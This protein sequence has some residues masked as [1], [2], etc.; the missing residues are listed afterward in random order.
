MVLLH[1]FVCSVCLNFKVKLAKQ[2]TL[3]CEFKSTSDS[4]D[5]VYRYSSLLVC[6][7]DGNIMF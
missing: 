1:V 7:M 4:T 3:L 2:I 5:L 6:F